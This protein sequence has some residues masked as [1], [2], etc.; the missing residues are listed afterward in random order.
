MAMAGL[1]PDLDHALNVMAQGEGWAPFAQALRNFLEEGDRQRINLLDLNN[2][3]AN[4][5]AQLEIQLQAAEQRIQHLAARRPQS[6]PRAAGP[7]PPQ[8]QGAGDA[9]LSKIVKDP[10]EFDGTKGRKFEEWWTKVQTWQ[11]ANARVLNGE[12]AVRAVLS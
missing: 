7:P 10:G 3:R 8:P 4:D 12:D 1:P 9:R 2:T 6:P 5:I 11:A